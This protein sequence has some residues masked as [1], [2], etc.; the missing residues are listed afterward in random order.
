MSALPKTSLFDTGSESKE[1]LTIFSTG[2]GQDSM[3]ILLKIIYDQ[4]FRE[5]YVPGGLEN[6]IILHSNTG[7]DHPETYKYEEDVFAPLCAEHNLK[8]VHITPEMGFHG[9]NWSSLD[10]QWASGDRHTIGSIAFPHKSCT[11]QL[12]IKPQQD[13]IE[14]W[15]ADTYGYKNSRKAAYKG[16]AAFHGKIKWLIGIAKG[17]ERRVAGAKAEV[18]KWRRES[19]DM[20]Y[21]LIE[22]G[23]DRTACQNYIQEMGYPLPMPSNC[24][25]CE[26]VSNS[27]IE[28]LWLYRHH[29][30][31]FNT[32]VKQEQE[33]LDDWTEQP[34]NLGACGKL[35]KKGDRKGQAVTLMDTLKEALELY[36]DMSL[37]DLQA[38]KWS[39]GNCVLSSY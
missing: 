3:G 10:A 7:S 39:H 16:F 34:K 6:L 31:V 22:V 9:K 32:W 33:K 17:E 13:Y 1:Q 36:G 26:Y 23:M 4:N 8:Y 25:K 12:K 18:V 21:P 11:H 20:V 2:L 29:E 38:Y 15:L 24:M 27:H 19:I 30:S 28:L 5:T 14:Q 35:H 37:E